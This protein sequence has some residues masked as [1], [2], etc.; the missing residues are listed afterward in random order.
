MPG[1]SVP[2]QSARVNV[3]AEH[4]SIVLLS[5]ERVS[6]IS[7]LRLRMTIDDNLRLEQTRVL[8]VPGR[9]YCGLC[10]FA[11]CGVVVDCNAMR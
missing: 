2:E 6:E 10:T 7:I 9:A 8:L 1:V 11:V 4:S 5:H 3:T